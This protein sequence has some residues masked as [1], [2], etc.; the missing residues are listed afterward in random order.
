MK[1]N[2][3]YVCEPNKIKITAESVPTNSKGIKVTFFLNNKEVY[4]MSHTLKTYTPTK[5]DIHTHVARCCNFLKGTTED[6]IQDRFEE[7][8]IMGI[9]NIHRSLSRVRTPSGK[10]IWRS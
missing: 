4:H 5:D 2:H 3:R 7:S 8:N 6:Y 9:L 10:T 1:Y